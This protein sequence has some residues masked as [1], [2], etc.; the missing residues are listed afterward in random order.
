MVE[1]EQTFFSSL[2][3]D[4]YAECEEHL[5]QVRGALLDLD[6]FVQQ[7]ELDQ[8]LLEALLR[9][10]HTIKGLSGM[11]SLE[12]AEKLAHDIES[13]VR[14]LLREH[15]VLTHAG[16]NALIGGVKTL[17]R[18]IGA[19]R[20][21]QPLPDVAPVVAELH[22]LVE[23]R[24][25]G[26]S[27]ET[28]TSP[29]QPLMF[30]SIPLSGAEQAKLAAA[31]QVGA[32]AYHC[33]FT[34]DPELARQGINVNT[35]RQR[36]QELGTL[37]HAAPQVNGEGG[38]SFA[39]LVVSQL[40]EDGLK[41]LHEN[42]VQFTRCEIPQQTAP[43]G[44]QEAL[45]GK[46][47]LPLREVSAPVQG[48]T[49][50]APIDSS[51]STASRIPSLA[52]ANIVRVDLA[53]L[54][55]LM[56]MVGE[57]VI[58]RARLDDSLKRL[59]PALAAVDLSH[60]QQVNLVM[61]RQLRD[62]REG[63]MR[64]RMVPVGEV[65]ERMRFVVHDLARELGVK[66]ELKI[67]GA[68]T[69]IDK[70]IVERML[71]PLLHLVRNAVSHS[72][73]SDNERVSRGKP[74]ARKVTLRAGTSGDSVLI[75]IADDGCGIDLSA[76]ADRARSA[77]M[78][79]SDTP[80]DS[81]NLLEILSHPGFST[82]DQA[83]LASGR[84]IGMTVVAKAVKEL[85]GSLTLNTELHAGTRFT[86][87][88]PLTLAILDALIVTVADQVFAVPLTVVREVVAI[89]NE[90][91][92]LLENNEI[93]AYRDGVL[94]LIRLSRL[95]RLKGSA[96]PRRHYALVVADASRC[97]GIVIDRVVGQ[98][99]IVVRALA[100]PLVQVR[101]V[102]GATELGDGR[103]VLILDVAAIIQTVRQR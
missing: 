102:A 37:I 49:G 7:P 103:V 86:I 87:Q 90:E 46:Q 70:F 91:V 65:F 1:S 2:L 74:A 53:K 60:L 26:S 97:T 95:F 101:G 15:L 10:F 100:D 6:S 84:G 52:A 33:Q 80:V 83:D 19:H 68:E 77:G 16:M 79:G 29:P 73:E 5:V 20:L 98:R 51:A 63:V 31:L 17:D 12:A 11:V 67:I 30:S 94:P 42:G 38:I 41:P 96:T 71:D 61:E 76:V 54:D 44:I 18:V 28:S 40:E 58:S 24:A 89:G 25:V 69:E 81:S 78:I 35:V 8:S 48:Q 88:L 32:S 66:V 55:D 82:R 45:P 93:L 75:E 36:L 99:E 92:T 85:A 21:H 64:V 57:M 47:G 14:S 50:R 72:L 39:F 22:A 23:N 13:Y 4:Y 34:P 43:D 9:S 27:D 56:R 3:D 62:L 59:D